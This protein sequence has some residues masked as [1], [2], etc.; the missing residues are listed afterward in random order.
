MGRGWRRAEVARWRTKLKDVM[1]GGERERGREKTYGGGCGRGEG[2]GRG[3]AEV[4]EVASIHDS[5]IVEKDKFT[6]RRPGELLRGGEG[7]RR[8][9]GRLS[10]A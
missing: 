9:S 4:A 2:G 5:T 10:Q 3:K 6:R 7:E 1:L 8:G